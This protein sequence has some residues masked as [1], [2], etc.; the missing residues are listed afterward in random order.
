MPNKL[1]DDEIQKLVYL[2]RETQFHYQLDQFSNS[3]LNEILKSVGQARREVS[4]KL[5]TISPSSSFT[6]ERLNAIATELQDLTVGIRAQVTGQIEQ[7]VAVVGKKAYAKH[8]DI[9]SFG[10]LVPNFNNVSL[11]AVQ[12]KAIINTPVGGNLLNDWVD[13]TFDSNLYGAFTQEITTGL[14]KGDSYKNLVKRFNTEAFSKIESDVEGLTRTYV[15]SINTSAMDNV[16]KANADIMKGWKWNSVYENRS[17]IRCISLDAKGE[18]YP[19]GGGPPIPLH[20]NCRCFPEPITKTFR[21]L[22]VDIDE[23]KDSYRPYTIRGKIDPITGKVIPGKIGVG[24]GRI[25]ETGRFLGTYEDFF[26]GLPEN[27]QLQMLG[28]TRLGLYKSGKLKLSGLADSKGNAFLLNELKGG[29]KQSIFDSFVP[30]TEQYSEI[31]NKVYY[32]NTTKSGK[33]AI[34]KEGW[35]VQPAKSGHLYGDGVYF[36]QSEQNLRWGDEVIK[37]NVSPKR[38][39]YDPEGYLKYE[40]TPLGDAVLSYSPGLKNEATDPKRWREG[41]QKFLKAG[42]YDSILT[43]E[44]DRTI[45]VALDESII[46]KAALAKKEAS[47][48]AQ[49]SLTTTQQKILNFANTTSSKKYSPEK[50][51]SEYNKTVEKED[52]LTLD[53][54][55]AL[56]KRF[57]DEVPLY[58]NRGLTLDSDSYKAVL[59]TGEFKN[60]FQ[61]KGLVTSDSSDALFDPFIKGDRDKWEVAYSNKLFKESPGYS[62][63]KKGKHFTSVLADERPLYGYLNDSVYDNRLSGL[64]GDVTFELKKDI[65]KR[66]TI[67]AMDSSKFN[68]KVD[69]LQTPYNSNELLDRLLVTKIASPTMKLTEFTIEDFV[70]AQIYGGVK[71]D[72]DIAKIITKTRLNHIQKLAD[73]WNIPYE[74]LDEL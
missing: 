15:Q 39:L 72:R 65:K 47:K 6:K 68:S 2:A 9:M 7:T 41:L 20:V 34:E 74:V 56:Q 5:A 45:F 30:D 66:T 11:T 24:G 35:K 51:L 52:W 44:Y 48:V 67:T 60:Q 33:T 8:A 27:V 58:M 40:G 69:T 46:K 38:T 12:L 28:P 1:T 29:V 22:G 19:V 49:V 73:K 50:I 59:E 55:K 23:V 70:E 71:L 62:D 42:K 61:L 17:C 57:G 64:Y 54:Y 10:G 14:L 31:I 4:A 16:M 18:I 37:V 26:K 63:L 36:S 3:A 32:H 13:K 53:S 21:E 43:M 25:I